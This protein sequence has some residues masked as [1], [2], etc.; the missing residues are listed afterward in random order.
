[1]LSSWPVIFLLAQGRC[2]SFRTVRHFCLANLNALKILH[3]LLCP[4]FTEARRLFKQGADLS[5]NTCRT[6][7]NM[8]LPRGAIARFSA[9]IHSC[10]TGAY[11]PSPLYA[12]RYWLR[13]GLRYFVN[14]DYYRFFTTWNSSSYYVLC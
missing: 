2:M 6:F 10:V 4:L 7:A 8:H 11:S 12:R 1:M 5:A 3:P 13:L 9:A 14:H